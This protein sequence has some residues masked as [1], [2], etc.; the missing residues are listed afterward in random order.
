M[1]Q[2][3]AGKKAGKALTEEQKQKMR[4]ELARLSKLAEQVVRRS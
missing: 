2:P 4:A 3:K 1:R